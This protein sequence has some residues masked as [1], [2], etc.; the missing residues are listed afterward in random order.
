MNWV[1][2]F[3]RKHPRFG[4]PNLMTYVV[5][6]MLFVFV[7]DAVFPDR[8]LSSLLYF[9]RDLI[10]QGQVWRLVTFIFLPPNSS[11][12]FI[13]FSLYFYFMVGRSL[14]TEWGVCAFTIYYL[15]GIVGTIAAGFITGSTT[16]IFL[17]YSL[18]FAFAILYPDFQLLVF[19]ILPVKIKYLAF[20]NA[21]YFLYAIIAGP[22]PNRAAVIVSL[23]NLIIFF[24]G[25]FIK[26]IK[27]DSQYRETRRNFRQQNRSSKMDN[28]NRY[29]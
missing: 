16:N 2:K 4:I 24:G 3:E 15:I 14:E 17:N 5:I 19:F 1:Y 20:L 6:G 28:D 11:L 12:F 13:V 9:N 18:Y 23:I 26:K 10:L 8:T 22:W 29:R 25:T 27:R 21:L 7:M